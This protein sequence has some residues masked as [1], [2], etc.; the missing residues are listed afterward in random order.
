MLQSQNF[1]RG[2]PK[3]PLFESV[4]EVVEARKMSPERKETKKE[5]R[6]HTRLVFDTWNKLESDKTRVKEL[7]GT[8]KLTGDQRITYLQGLVHTVERYER[9]VYMAELA[10]NSPEYRQRL[11]CF[12]TGYFY[13]AF[14]S[15]VLQ[16]WLSMGII[17]THHNYMWP[18]L[19]PGQFVTHTQ[20]LLG[21]RSRYQG[22]LDQ[23]MSK[24]DC[25]KFKKWYV[26]YLRN[27]DKYGRRTDI[28]DHI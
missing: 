4:L 15:V 24:D 3:T 6:A 27:H 5:Q 20:S 23:E 8:I 16:D 1:L 7:A 11:P 19:P 21:S 14:G 18:F 9:L 10:Q 2:K 12:N 13:N 17:L 22:Y 26:L 25:T 28:I